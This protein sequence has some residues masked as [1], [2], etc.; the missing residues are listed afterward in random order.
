MQ[1]GDLDLGELTVTARGRV[2]GLD[3][4]ATILIQAWLDRR[5]SLGRVTGR[6]P[7]TTPDLVK[8]TADES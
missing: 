2:L 5:Q 3:D 7:P 6:P 4:H 8:L 1:L